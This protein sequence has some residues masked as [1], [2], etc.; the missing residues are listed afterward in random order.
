ML[1]KDVVFT[2]TPT[3]KAAFQSLKTALAQ[4]PVLALLDFK[5]TFVIETDASNNG[6]RAVLMQEGHPISYLS[7]ALGPKAQ[8]LSTYEKECLAVILAVEKLFTACSIYIGNRSQESDTLARSKNQQ[9]Y[10]T[11]N[12]VEVIGTKIYY[13]IQERAGKYCS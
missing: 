4:A 6:I 5:K 3:T 12:V 2:W 8:A 9:S 13:T 1:K 7:K 11:E 10:A